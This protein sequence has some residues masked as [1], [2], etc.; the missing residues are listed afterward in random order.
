MTLAQAYADAFVTAGCIN[1]K[2]AIRLHFMYETT[3]EQRKGRDWCNTCE[4][5][6]FIESHTPDKDYL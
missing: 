3:A 5:V 2:N 6:V 1:R 4:T